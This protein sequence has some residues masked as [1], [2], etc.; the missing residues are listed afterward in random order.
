MVSR[1]RSDANAFDV[2]TK[3][4]V[5]AT[6]SCRGDALLRFEV[7]ISEPADARTTTNSSASSGGPAR[8]L[9][10]IGE[11]PQRAP[12]HERRCA[13]ISRRLAPA[14]RRLYCGQD[15]RALPGRPSS[16]LIATKSDRSS[17]I[18]GPSGE[19]GDPSQSFWKYAGPNFAS[20]ILNVFA[21][22]R[23]RHMLE[24]AFDAGRR[25]VVRAPS[26]EMVAALN[27]RLWT[28]DDASF[29]LMARPATANRRLTRS[30]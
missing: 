2:T 14:R 30:S 11:E 18:V 4:D 10:W 13:R 20:I 19:K 24:R 22:T 28:Y 1:T 21:L 23:R 27:D 16:G 7:R 25:I 6:L 9:G 5:D 26:D 12:P 29:C 8:G 3:V 15:R 17:V